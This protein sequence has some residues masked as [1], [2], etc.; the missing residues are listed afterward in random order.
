MRLA[1]YIAKLRFFATSIATLRRD[2][3]RTSTVRIRIGE[4]DRR[5][6]YTWPDFGLD[7]VIRSIPAR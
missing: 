6:R 3:L 5:Y 2:R 4:T 1:P 7:P